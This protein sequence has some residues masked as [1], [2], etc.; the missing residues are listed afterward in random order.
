MRQN[1]DR[2]TSGSVGGRHKSDAVHS[3]CM[4]LSLSLSL[5]IFPFI[6]LSHTHR[7]SISHKYP[8]PLPNL[9]S[10][11]WS[12]DSQ[13]SLCAYERQKKSLVN[14]AQLQMETTDTGQMS[15]VLP[16]YKNPS[17]SIFH[18]QTQCWK[19]TGILHCVCSAEVI[20]K[21]HIFSSLYSLSWNGL[22]NF[23]KLW[24]EFETHSETFTGLRTS[25]NFNST[26]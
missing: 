10:L 15:N 9:I 23:L 25:L 22:S 17:I 4:S 6:Y 12:V 1:M 8:L 13:L 2:C 20:K 5:S 18:T 3:L 7:N 16:F 19:P 24:L 21:N 26:C 11:I 14:Q